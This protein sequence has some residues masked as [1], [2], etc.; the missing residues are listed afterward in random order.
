[1]NGNVVLRLF[2]ISPVRDCLDVFKQE[3]KNK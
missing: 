3:P 1:M 2:Y